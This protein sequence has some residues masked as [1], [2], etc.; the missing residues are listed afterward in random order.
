MSETRKIAITVGALFLFSNIIFLVGAVGLVEPVLNDPNYLSLAFESRNQVVLGALLE[1]LNAVAYIGIA[2]LVFPIL[3]NRFESMALWY[4]CFRIIEFVMQTLSDLAPLALVKLSEEFV[5]AGA[6]AA[7]A[8]EALGSL[9]LIERYWAF[10]GVTFALVLGALVF[11]TMLYRSRL[12]P[13]F[14]SVWGIIAVL[15][16]FFTALVDSFG[17]DPG[18][19]DYLGILM[20]LNEVFLG[21]WL[22]VKGFDLSAIEPGTAK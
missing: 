22:I 1:I 17:I 5:Q 20:L 4:V 16:V 21:V 12:V 10:Q 19:L 9:L 8:F 11:Y 7:P 2:V 3:R 15:A 6:Q 14:I 13:R 18:Y